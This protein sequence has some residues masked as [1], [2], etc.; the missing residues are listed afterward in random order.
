MGAG[1]VELDETWDWTR[2]ERGTGIHIDD[3][4][5]SAS[6]NQSIEIKTHAYGGCEENSGGG[7]RRGSSQNG[8]PMGSS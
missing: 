7:G 4:L 8:S 5:D 3:P 1:R 6:T 2:K